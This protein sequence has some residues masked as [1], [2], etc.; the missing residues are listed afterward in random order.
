MPRDCVFFGC[1]DAEI[2]GSKIIAT[3]RGDLE[4]VDVRYIF[5]SEPEKIKGR[6]ALATAQVVRGLKSAMTVLPSFEDGVTSIGAPFFLISVWHAGWTRLSDSQRV[7]LIDHELAHCCFEL[8][9]ETDEGRYSTVGHDIE[10]FHAIVRRHG[11]WMPEYREFVREIED[12]ESGQ[13]PLLSVA[14]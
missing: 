4:G 6:K 13:P 11:A 7:A 8:D 9:A 2:I 14:K 1:P 5:R 12:F 3:V 10:E